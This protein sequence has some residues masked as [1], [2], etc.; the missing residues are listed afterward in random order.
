V[1][2]AARTRGNE[3]SIV[4]RSNALLTYQLTVFWIVNQKYRKEKKRKLI[5]TVR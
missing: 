2:A 5:H 1:R 3:I 4:M